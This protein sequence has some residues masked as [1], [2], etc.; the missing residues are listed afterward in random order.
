MASRTSSPP[1]GIIIGQLP[2]K[3]TGSASHDIDRLVQISDSTKQ[4]VISEYGGPN[5]PDKRSP[6]LEAPKPTNAKG[7][8]SKPRRGEA[9]SSTQVVGPFSPAAVMSLLAPNSTLRRLL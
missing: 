9:S 4:D 6:I 7:S 5:A 3:V 1:Q 2:P 8:N